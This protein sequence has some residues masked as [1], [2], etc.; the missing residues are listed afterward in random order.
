MSKILL[1]DIENAPNL[2]YVWAKYEQDVLSYE[3]EWYM[4]S[5]AYKWLGEKTTRC[6]AL[7]NYKGYTRDKED[8][9]FL[10]YDLWN[11]LD[12]ADIVI[13]HNVDR[14]DIRK[15]N[16]RFL[17]HGMNPPSYYRTVDTV[18]L[19]RKH[20]M[21]NSNKLNDLAG[22]LNLGKKA[23][24][25][26]FQLWLDCMA[27]KASAWKQMIAYNKQDVDLLE[28]VYMVLRKWATNHPNVNLVKDHNDGCPICGG[29]KD[30]QKRGFRY[31][32]TG[33]AQ[34]YQHLSCG[35][36]FHGPYKKV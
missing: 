29:K 36:W 32:K 2:G 25:G 17:K 27:G 5:F 9:S 15:I 13:G 10:L 18:K 3:K 19:A 1:L 30:I 21:L 34:A 28:D 8:D 14:F 20:F 35:G 23:P 24:T 33:K 22:Y 4:L 7:P 16:A 31:S 26:G 12:E 11:L 6:K